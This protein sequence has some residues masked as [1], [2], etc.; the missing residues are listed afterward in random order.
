MKI[1]V[2]SQGAGLLLSSSG[3]M[4]AA[5]P[6][7]TPPRRIG[8]CIQK[9]SFPA[10]PRRVPEAV[11]LC[12]EYDF[13]DSNVLKRFISIPPESIT[14]QVF[15]FAGGDGSEKERSPAKHA[16][17]NGGCRIIFYG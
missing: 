12:I 7:G 6:D 11:I 3:T 8:G 1:V 2:F 10:V 4:I 16:G 17:I 5:A 14:H 15:R 9:N 13:H